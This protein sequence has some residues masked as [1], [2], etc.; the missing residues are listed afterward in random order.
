M[1][2]W[3]PPIQEIPEQEELQIDSC[4][5]NNIEGSLR[6]VHVHDVTR[7]IANV[8][9]ISWHGIVKTWIDGGVV[10]DSSHISLLI[11][12]IDEFTNFTNVS[13]ID[14]SEVTGTSINLDF[15]ICF[16]DVVGDFNSGNLY[17]EF[18]LNRNDRIIVPRD[19]N[20]TIIVP[21]ASTQSDLV[22]FS[23]DLLA[24]QKLY[25]N[26]VQLDSASME[27]VYDAWTVECKCCA[28]IHLVG[29]NVS[30]EYL[31]LFNYRMIDVIQ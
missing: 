10:V 26:G 21:D 31:E 11:E 4:V 29:H 9:T 23:V 19:N 16:N 20:G 7:D 28:E 18:D 6:C 25:F 12:L 22:D 14:K 30:Q 17:F 5:L 15:T 2:G 1:Y 13:W 3:N 8:A 24:Y 27:P